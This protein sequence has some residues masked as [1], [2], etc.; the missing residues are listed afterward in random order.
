M[1]LFEFGVGVKKSINVVNSSSKA[2]L[3]ALENYKRAVEI[4]LSTI[5]GVIGGVNAEVV[6]LV[7]YLW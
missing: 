5:S 2:L 3:N 7:I 4:E 6:K 1:K